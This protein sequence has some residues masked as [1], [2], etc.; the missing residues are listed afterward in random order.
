IATPMRGLTGAHD[1]PGAKEG[2]TAGA[3]RRRRTDTA[4]V[5]PDGRQQVRRRKPADDN[6]DVPTGTRP[7]RPARARARGAGLL[8]RAE[9]LRQEPGAVPGPPRVGVLRGP[10]H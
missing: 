6:A 7:G 5:P 9:Y 2:G 8:A 3:R 4:L 1:A 10:A